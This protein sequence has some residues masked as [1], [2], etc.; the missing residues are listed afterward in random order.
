MSLE[1]EDPDFR[2]QYV[3]KQTYPMAPVDIGAALE[4]AHR[5]LEALLKLEHEA[6]VIVAADDSK[7]N[8]GCAI[9]KALGRCMIFEEEILRQ[10]KSVKGDIV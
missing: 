10:A 8:L 7:T 5:H 1:T 4:E 3:W 9:S 6:Q 2:Q